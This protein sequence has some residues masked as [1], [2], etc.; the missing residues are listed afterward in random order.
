[1]IE[2]EQGNSVLSLDIKYSNSTVAQEG[3]KKTQ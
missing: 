1:M 3:R 2:N